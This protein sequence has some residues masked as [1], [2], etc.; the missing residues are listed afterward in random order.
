MWWGF[1]ST[2]EARMSK[3]HA[4]FA[5]LFTCATRVTLLRALLIP[6]IAW[7]ITE[8]DLRSAFWLAT[9]ALVTDGI[10]G[11]LARRYNQ[12]TVFG[13]RFDQL[14]DKA[15]A[16]TI[17]VMLLMREHSKFDEWL[18]SIGLLCGLVTVLFQFVLWLH[19]IKMV[20]DLIDKTVA[21]A[22]SIGAI[23]LLAPIDPEFARA[24]ILAAIAGWFGIALRAAARYG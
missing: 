13:G 22:G 8:N 15:L 17:V 10:D 16:T 6:F 19:N 4:S 11:R 14:T 1:V 2:K 21:V 23:M 20:V 24:I 18:L 12:V 3:N 5:R 7:R 9:F